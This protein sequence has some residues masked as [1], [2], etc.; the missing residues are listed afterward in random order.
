MSRALTHEDRL[1]IFRNVF[2]TL[3][4]RDRFTSRANGAM[5]DEELRRALED[6]MGIEGGSCRQDR[7]Y[8]HYRRAGLK[9]WGDWEW[10]SPFRDQPLWQEEATLR[11]AREVYG[12]AD[13]NVQQMSLL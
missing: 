4:R 2:G 5:T 10:A 9:I 1:H 3:G 12:I 11:M 6:A 7:P 8:V 13:P